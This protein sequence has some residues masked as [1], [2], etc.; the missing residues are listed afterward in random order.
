MDTVYEE[1]TITHLD[2]LNNYCEE[3]ENIND[4][5]SDSEATICAIEEME[6]D[7][8]YDEKYNGLSAEDLLRLI[9]SD[10]QYM[11]NTFSRGDGDRVGHESPIPN[12]ADIQNFFL[13]A[14]DLASFEPFKDDELKIKCSVYPNKCGLTLPLDK[15]TKKLTNKHN[16]YKYKKHG[17]RNSPESSKPRRSPFPKCKE[18]AEKT[19]SSVKTQ[20]SSTDTPLFFEKA[21][22]LSKKVDSGMSIK[23]AA[24]M[25]IKPSKW[26]S[27]CKAVFEKVQQASYLGCAVTL[28]QEMWEQYLSNTFETIRQQ[29][30]QRATTVDFCNE[31]RQMIED[32]ERYVCQI[33]EEMEPT[34]FSSGFVI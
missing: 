1:N 21:P 30:I 7:I 13:K 18:T 29:E 22:I 34:T 26:T 15:L 19:F 5:D 4:D 10:Q 17:S 32:D 23:E 33:I 28:L 11:D 24:D 12:A 9:I 2:V 25:T 31:V 6:E 14:M 20:I 3:Y 27:E 16:H 8:R